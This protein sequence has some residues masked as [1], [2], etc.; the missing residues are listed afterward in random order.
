VACAFDC[1]DEHSLMLRT[2]SGDSLWDDPT[3]FRNESLEFLF[4]LVIDIV[5][6]VIAEAA[7]SLFSNLPGC[8]SL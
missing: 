1:R 8:A 5:F 6:F 3:L 2:C 7:R 4:R